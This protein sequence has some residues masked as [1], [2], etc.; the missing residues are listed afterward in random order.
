MNKF[1]TS[2]LSILIFTNTI[3]AQ[4]KSASPNNFASRLKK[5]SFTANIA[6]TKEIPL[7]KAI[8]VN[9]L[10][11]NPYRP[12][13]SIGAEYN[14]KTRPKFRKYIG[15]ELNVHDYKYV[16]K[17]FG[18]TLIGGADYKIYKG[19]Y[20]GMAVG[21]GL[22]KAKRADIVYTYEA[23]KGWVG[24]PYDGK[25]LYNRQ[26]L[27]LQLEL[28]YRLPKYGVDVFFGANAMAI[29]NLY[30]SEVPFW[31]YQSPNK[32]GIRKTF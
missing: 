6:N 31:F 18:I 17:S 11:S 28:G 14:Y 10:F 29:R 9:N 23:T 27:R 2:I 8:G 5:F 24:A 21:L 19:L 15:A 1:I 3:F 7:I 13:Y 32:F 30:G 26:L 25:Y 12:M 16:E 4:S 22:Q 20:A